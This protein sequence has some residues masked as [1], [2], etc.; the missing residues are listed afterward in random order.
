MML[1]RFWEAGKVGYSIEKAEVHK[2]EGKAQV[3][4]E[5]T[6]LPGVARRCSG[7]CIIENNAIC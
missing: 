4:I 1:S 7:Y 2:E 5:L 3:W 6:P